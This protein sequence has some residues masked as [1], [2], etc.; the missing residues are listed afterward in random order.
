MATIKWL[1]SKGQLFDQHC[2]ADAAGRGNLE[3]IKEMRRSKAPGTGESVWARWNCGA[4]AAAAEGGHVEVLQWLRQNGC[5][6]G[7]SAS[8]S[9][10]Y[11]AAWGGHLDVLKWAR[12]QDPP[13]PWNMTVCS[14]AAQGG[15]L[16]ILKWAR[17][18]DPPCPWNMAVCSMAADGG[19]LEVLKWA[20]SQDPPC[21]WDERTCAD[22]ARGGHLEVLKWARSQDPPCPWSRDECRSIASCRFKRHHHIVTW[23]D[24]QEVESNVE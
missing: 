7:N 1:R 16:D 14:V 15:H 2:V 22:A 21:P 23:I 24:Q 5:P 12:S 13:C 20:R 4:V 19:H 11:H 9:T 8:D 17:S 18:Q 6:W 3:A 10:C